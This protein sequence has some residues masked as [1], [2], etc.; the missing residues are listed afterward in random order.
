MRN[1]LNKLYSKSK[2]SYKSIKFTRLKFLVPN[3][4]KYFKKFVNYSL[5][6]LTFR[7]FVLLFLNLTVII[8]LFKYYP[9]III[10]K[11]SLF[12]NE[13]EYNE[14][15]DEI[16]KQ[17]PNKR[18]LIKSLKNY[19]YNQC[20]INSKI[21]LIL[22]CIGLFLIF[23]S[24]CLLDISNF[25]DFDDWLY[26]YLIKIPDFHTFIGNI[27]LDKGYS[28]EEYL[29]DAQY[30]LLTGRE[31]T[32]SNDTNSISKLFVMLDIWSFDFRMH[33]KYTIIKTISEMEHVNMV[34]LDD[35]FYILT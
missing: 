20:S 33:C 6:K 16:F 22:T 34:S 11:L 31:G 23:F 19:Y 4:K 27:D 8:L 28:E 15:I 21:E 17:C 9:S 25:T 5:L 2:L 18:L 35:F 30:L 13:K 24:I 12:L 10:N 26:H 7:F 3:F 1:F 14:L 29:K 32:L